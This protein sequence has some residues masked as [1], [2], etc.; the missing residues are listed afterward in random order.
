MLDRSRGESFP[1]GMEGSHDVN[2]PVPPPS[3]SEAER[4]DELMVAVVGPPGVGKTTIVTVLA[5]A[6]GLTVFRLREAVRV[7]ADVLA[8]LPP[9]TDP[10]GWVGIG[11]VRRVLDRTFAA[12]PL[13]T[14][15]GVVLLDNFPGTGAQLDL[16]VDVAEATGRRVALLEL[17]AGA[18]TV[19]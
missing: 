11:A 18:A 16:L 8:D 5:E 1:A 12:G 4:N 6:E 2:R 13:Q 10:L 17:R 9:S 7:H 3:V 14:G 15:R 19:T